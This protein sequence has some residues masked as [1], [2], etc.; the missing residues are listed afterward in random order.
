MDIGGTDI[1]ALGKT[2]LYMLIDDRIDLSVLLF[3]AGIL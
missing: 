2:S 3:I 1:E